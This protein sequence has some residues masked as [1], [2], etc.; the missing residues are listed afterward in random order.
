MPC[1][2]TYIW[3]QLGIGEF[4]LSQINIFVKTCKDKSE[5]ISFY[6]KV[7][8]SPLVSCHIGIVL[9]PHLL[10]PGCARIPQHE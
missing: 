8:L 9:Y 6:Q 5:M 2:A 3:V 10:D 4:S 1:L 7:M